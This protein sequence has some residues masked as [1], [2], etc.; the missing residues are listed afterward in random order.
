MNPDTAER[1]VD[2]PAHLHQ[3]YGHILCGVYVEVTEP[4]HIG[5]GDAAIL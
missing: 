3:Q 2:V 1:D 5:E 4:G